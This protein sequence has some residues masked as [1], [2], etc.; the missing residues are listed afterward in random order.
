MTTLLS[1]EAPANCAGHKKVFLVTR[2][3]MGP[4]NDLVLPSLGN[5]QQAT[6]TLQWANW[7]IDT[8]QYA[9]YICIF[10]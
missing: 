7:A 9:T 6:C 2:K 5:M 10:V 3:R 8:R 1:V 4:E